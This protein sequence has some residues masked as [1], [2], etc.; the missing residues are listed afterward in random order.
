[1][2]TPPAA[3]GRARS[4]GNLAWSGLL[5]LAA[6][7]LMGSVIHGG[8]VAIAGVPMAMAAAAAALALP[9]HRSSPPRPAGSPQSEMSDPALAAS[10][11]LSR[12]MAD[13]DDPDSALLDMLRVVAAA[14]GSTTALLLVLG[15]ADTTLRLEHPTLVSGRPGEP[16]DRSLR[17]AD[18]GPIRMALAAGVAV[19]A[20]RNPV[21]P[22]A[23]EHLASEHGI[24]AAAIVPLT[25]AGAQFAAMVLATGETTPSRSHLMRLRTIMPA[26]GGAIGATLRLRD[27]AR[28]TARSAQTAR[29]R[30][31]YAAVVGH[32]LRTPLTTILGV[33]K[34][35]ERPG[36]AP[37]SD[38][39]RELLAMAN[40]QGDRLKRLV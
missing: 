16:K 31:D 32:E 18:S 21:D 22:P 38:D 2:S 15:D 10:A 27:L 28:T 19:S 37:E 33:I 7:F 29:F 40:A 26:A 1:M 11:E 20:K 6:G 34:T 36:M 23:W 9:A 24:E 17:V 4:A 5:W 39:A 3:G 13:F 14:I 12:A 8:L 30:A 25:V 35:L